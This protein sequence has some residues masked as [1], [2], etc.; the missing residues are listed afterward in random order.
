[1]FPFSLGFLLYGRF[2]LTDS[3]AQVLIFLFQLLAG[4][5]YMFHL[6]FNQFKLL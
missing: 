6:L 1:M 5:N 4:L 3:V 2:Q